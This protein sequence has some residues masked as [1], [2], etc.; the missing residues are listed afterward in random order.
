MLNCTPGR[1]GKENKSSNQNSTYVMNRSY[2]KYF[3]YNPNLVE[4][5]KKRVA[6]GM[7]NRC[8]SALPAHKSRL[9]RREERLKEESVKIV[10][11]I[12]QSLIKQKK[13]KLQGEFEYGGSLEGKPAHSSLLDYLK[14]RS[15]IN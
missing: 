15:L 2:N 6:F 3:N 13:E 11:M 5:Q 4:T 7:S 8:Q 9:Q 10:K 14:S 12:R 1:E